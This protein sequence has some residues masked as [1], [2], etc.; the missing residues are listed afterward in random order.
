MFRFILFY[1]FIFIL[2]YFILFYLFIIIY[3]LGGGILLQNNDS[4]PMGFGNRNIIIFSHVLIKDEFYIIIF[5]HIYYKMSFS[6]TFDQ[7]WNILLTM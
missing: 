4:R 2:F 5:S 7:I 3:F 6:L 1:D